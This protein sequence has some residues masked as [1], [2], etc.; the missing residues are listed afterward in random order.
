M[1]KAV[2]V[3]PVS[4]SDIAMGTKFARPNF[5]A[6]TTAARDSESLEMMTIERAEAAQL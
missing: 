1:S 3:V 5:G 6:R 2:R 4:L